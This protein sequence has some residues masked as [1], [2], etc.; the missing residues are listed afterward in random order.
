MCSGAPSTSS[1]LA[2]TFGAHVPSS[3][4]LANR[5]RS[6]HKRLMHIDV[7]SSIP[8]E[9][10]THPLGTNTETVIIIPVGYYTTTFIQS[11]TQVSAEV[12]SE[13]TP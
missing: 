1:I 8:Y 2:P 7:E 9:G 12:Q 11:G 3:V 13:S 4:L 6:D 10:A 5:T